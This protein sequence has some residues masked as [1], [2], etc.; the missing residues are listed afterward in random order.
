MKLVVRPY[1]ESELDQ[2]AAWYE[3]RQ[4]GLRDRFLRAVD[5]TL[6]RVAE[7]PQLYQVI[8]LDI[9]RRCP[10]QGFPYSVFYLVLGS[11]VEVIGVVHDA[12]H[13]AVWKRRRR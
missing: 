6:T 13:P 9:I 11:S 3:S 10:V 4:P 5:S 8:H 7:N 12:R 2:A 1:V